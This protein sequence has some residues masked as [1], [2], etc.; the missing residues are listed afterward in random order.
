MS[1]D[2]NQ[3]IKKAL[4][5]VKHYLKRHPNPLAVFDATFQTLTISLLKS[6][7]LLLNYSLVYNHSNN[8]VK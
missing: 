6:M 8:V 7:I 2:I 4:P 5:I 3:Q 1:E